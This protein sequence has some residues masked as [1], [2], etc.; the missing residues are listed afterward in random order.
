MLTFSAAWRKDCI[1]NFEF[2][3]CVSMRQQYSRPA[4]Y[5][6]VPYP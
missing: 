4:M 1:H 2:I 5:E 6:T 3:S